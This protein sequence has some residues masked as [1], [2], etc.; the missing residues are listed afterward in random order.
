MEY[1]HWNRRPTQKYKYH[2]S[3]LVETRV[4]DVQLIDNI[5]KYN[6]QLLICPHNENQRRGSGGV[7][8]VVK[9]ERNSNVTVI[10]KDTYKR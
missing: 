5:R 7:A 6:V 3:C 1:T 9:C 4:H 10:E 8:S 2:S